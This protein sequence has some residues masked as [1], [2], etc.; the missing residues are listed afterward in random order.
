[1]SETVLVVDLATGESSTLAE[2]SLQQVGLQERRDLQRWITRHP[3]LVGEGLLLITSEFDRWELREQ[4]VDD[5]LDVLFLDS[6]G[7]LVVAELK[8]DRASDTTDVQALK[9]AAFCSTL[10][11]DD[12]VEEFV[13]FHAVDDAASRDAILSHAPQIEEEGLGG[14]KIRLV[15]GSFGPSVTSVVLWLRDFG[16]DIGCVQVTA[17]LLDG[18]RATITARQLLP[19]PVAE[20]YTVRRR[21]REQEQDERVRSSRGSSSIQV[22]ANAGLLEA[23]TELR[24]GLDAITSSWRPAVEQ[25]LT[26]NPDAGV[27]EWNG[28]MA[29]R[30]IMWRHDGEL[31]SLTGL[32]KTVLEMAGVEPPEALPGPDYWLLPDGRSMYKASVE[33]RRETRTWDVDSFMEAL[34]QRA[35]EPAVAAATRLLT[36]GQQGGFR[37]AWGKGR[38][39]G[40]FQPVLTLAGRNYSPICV[41][42][43]GRVEIQ[44]L[45]LTQPPFDE[46]PLRKEFLDRLNAL[47]GIA[48]DEEVLTGRRP[49]IPLTDLS[50]NPDLANGFEA[51]LDWVMDEARK[52]NP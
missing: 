28:D 33:L 38:V 5:R 12:V 49:R 29:A 17:R 6:E 1:M 45:H 43:Y 4:R 2:A 8:R 3:D 52:A 48:L 27:A 25:L 50:A 30:S 15:A 18:E 32:T 19:L 24:L 13:R 40:S 16:V 31:Y 41:Y 20:D 42:T 37:I 44:F 21:R 26:T 35:G 11:V 36:W 47:P 39:D 22:L 10:T 14:T 23:G 51:T 9:Y 46:M 7:C 34:R